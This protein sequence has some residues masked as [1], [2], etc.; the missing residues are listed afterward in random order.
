[1]TVLCIITTMTI[2]LYNM[3]H[4]MSYMDENKREKRNYIPHKDIYIYIYI[5]PCKHRNTWFIRSWEYLVLWNQ[6]TWLIWEP[7]SPE[8]TTQTKNPEHNKKDILDSINIHWLQIK[9]HGARYFNWLTDSGKW[10]R[11]TCHHIYIYF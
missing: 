3:C 6:L 9:S 10:A 1:M 4:C 8:P 5:Y 7:G 2:G 11:I